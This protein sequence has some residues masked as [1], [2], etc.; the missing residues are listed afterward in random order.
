MSVF[1]DS[2]AHLAL[3]CEEDQHHRAAVDLLR[4]TPSLEFITSRFV[5]SE[6]LTR[7]ARLRGAAQAADYVRSI[8]SRPSYKVLPMLPEVFDAA[9]DT[10]VKYEDQGLSFVDCT[11]VVI[12]R[13]SRIRTIFT[14]DR[15][16]RKLGFQV[17]P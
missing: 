5:L 10:L 17:V 8:L 3:L 12:M 13:N 7:G 11:S 6:V 15:A 16:F 9:M 14:F 1:V 2:A 4:R